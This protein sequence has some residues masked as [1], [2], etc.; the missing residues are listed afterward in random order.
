MKSKRCDVHI[1]PVTGERAAVRVRPDE[2]GGQLMV[3]DLYIRPGGAVVGE[4]FHPTIEERFEVVRGRVGCKL[5]TTTGVAGPGDKLV[6]PAR[7]VHDWW[8]AGPEEALVRVEISPSARFQAMVMNI[9]GLAQDGKTDGKGRPNLLQLSLFAQ[10]FSD[11]VIFTEP[12]PAVQKILFSLLAPIARLAGYRGS[13]P[14]YLI[15]PPS[16]TMEVEE[17]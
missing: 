2:T 4:H 11:V 9:F 5:G 6:I 17:S 7:A 10:E 14:E 1:N 3:V 15:R 13:Y 8:N 12:P 16:E